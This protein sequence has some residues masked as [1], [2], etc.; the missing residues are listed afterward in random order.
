MKKL[1][2]TGSYF[3]PANKQGRVC[4]CAGCGGRAPADLCVHEYP[5]KWIPERWGYSET[6]NALWCSYCYRANRG[7]G[8]AQN[9]IVMVDTDCPS[10][11]EVLVIKVDA[12]VQKWGVSVEQIKALIDPLQGADR[13]SFAE[14]KAEL[15]ALKDMALPIQTASSGVYS[16]DEA[17]FAE[18][19]RQNDAL[20]ETMKTNEQAIADLTA[21]VAEFIQRDLETASPFDGL[22]YDA[23]D[24][25]AHTLARGVEA[26]DK[27]EVTKVEAGDKAEV[28]T[29]VRQFFK[30]AAWNVLAKC[31]VIT[32]YTEDGIA[33]LE[34]SAL[35][36]APTLLSVDVP[37][38][39]TRT[40][41]EQIMW[42][43][44]ALALH[45]ET[46]LGAEVH[47]VR[48]RLLDIFE[49]ASAESVEH[50]QRIEHIQRT[51]SIPET[52]V[53]LF[54]V[55]YISSLVLELRLPHQRGS[56]VVATCNREWWENATQP[57]RAFFVWH[58][59]C[60]CLSDARIDARHRMLKKIQKW[61]TEQTDAV[62]LSV[63]VD[64]RV[65]LEEM[66]TASARLAGHESRKEIQMESKAKTAMKEQLDATKRAL[67]VGAKLAIT[68]QAGE[69]FLDIAKEL[70]E[71]IPAINGMLESEDGRE[72][73]K[74]F[75]ALLLQ[76]LTM[77]TNFVPKGEVV[78]EIAGIQITASSFK[79]LSTKLATLRKFVP[80]IA[81][82]GEEM[83]SFSVKARVETEEEAEEAAKLLKE[84]EE[85]VEVELQDLKEKVG[86]DTA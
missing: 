34:F 37:T 76:T 1:F 65:H 77:Q 5:F 26:G 63:P 3:A 50:I 58:Q 52:F 40:E 22:H 68:D 13:S 7:V 47:A 10:K 73:V 56:Y 82:L 81:A 21:L 31:F 19:K 48:R 23:K 18:A 70:G 30:G 79:L 35:A 41:A 84:A 86:N 14:L 85:E 38:W 25:L 8:F 45:G 39:T 67:S 12:L 4:F 33:Q 78:R 16:F 57:D 27:L 46:V 15:K 28:T 2:E 80:K 75:M 51:L 29:D 9:H 61:I 83:E 64:V 60:N 71:D 20:I 55:R 54:E 11:S 66:F 36:D 59:L 24:Q 69:L 42:V 72:L 44:D 43:F 32:H 6:V 17:Q 74:L 53:D 49:N 62:L